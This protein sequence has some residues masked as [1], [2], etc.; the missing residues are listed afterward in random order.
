MPFYDAVNSFM[1]GIFSPLL[2][3]TLPCGIFW[4][5]YRKEENRKRISYPHMRWGG[6][7]GRGVATWALKQSPA[8]SRRV[9][10][11]QLCGE[12]DGPS[13]SGCPPA[14]SWG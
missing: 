13:H 7:G 14:V 5:H 9:V 2:T 8:D 12:A 10:H 3:Y 1:N 6:V 4:L 11:A